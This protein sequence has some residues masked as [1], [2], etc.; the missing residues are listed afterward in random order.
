MEIETISA[1]G[2]GVIATLVVIGGFYLIDYGKQ[3]TIDRAEIINAGR[4]F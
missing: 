4:V 3:N 1:F 2:F